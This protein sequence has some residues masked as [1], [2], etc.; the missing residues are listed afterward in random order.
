MNLLPKKK[1]VCIFFYRLEV[2]QEQ[3]WVGAG[4]RISSRTNKPKRSIHAIK[5]LGNSNK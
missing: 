3:S 2:E 4:W 5:S 1:N